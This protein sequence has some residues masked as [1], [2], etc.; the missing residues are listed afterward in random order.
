MAGIVATLIVVF[1]VPET[2]NAQ[3]KAVSLLP[4]VLNESFIERPLP[5][6]DQ[7]Q[8]D[9]AEEHGP[10]GTGLMFR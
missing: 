5:G 10:I 8:E 1:L 6:T 4:S 2:L 9:R 3:G 7:Q